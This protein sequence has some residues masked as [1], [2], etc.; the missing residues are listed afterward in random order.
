MA[1]TIDQQVALDEALVPSTAFQVTTDVPEI[2]MQ[3]FWATAKLHHNSIR[4]KM[5]TK[6]SV[7][8]LE[9]FREMLHINW[10]LRTDLDFVYWNRSRSFL[11]NMATTIE[12][13]TALDESLVPSTQRFM[14]LVLVFPAAIQ[15]E[16]DFSFNSWH[17][18]SES[19]KDSIKKIILRDRRHPWI[20]LDGVAPDKPFGLNSV[21]CC[22]QAQEN[23]FEAIMI[24]AILKAA[25]TMVKAL[26]KSYTYSGDISK[27]NEYSASYNK[28]IM[29]P[30]TSKVCY[31]GISFTKGNQPTQDPYTIE[32]MYGLLRSD[33]IGRIQGISRVMTSGDATITHIHRLT[34]DI[35][36]LSC[37]PCTTVTLATA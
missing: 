33:Y 26:E 32:L 19:A 17:V 2:Y 25:V 10:S 21:L 13:Q 7:L 16:L 22:K 30:S 15:A 36:N 8:D 3:E 5:D 1:T 24:N 9:A 23:G 18:I 34:I 12:Q 29:A 28:V 4:F 35:Q 31:G 11:R 37:N 27:W 6:K 14:L 20:S